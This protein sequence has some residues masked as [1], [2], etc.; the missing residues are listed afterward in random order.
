MISLLRDLK[1]DDKVA[2]QA[3]VFLQVLKDKVGLKVAIE[4]Q[5]LIKAVEASGK[6]TTRQDVGRVI[7]FYQPRL[8]EDGII[9]IEKIA[10]E[11]DAKPAKEAKG[12]P[13][14]PGAKPEAKAEGKG[15]KAA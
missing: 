5:D 10:E 14:K 6:M 11:K 12:E 15:K 1:E 13:S 8:Q 7:S 3:K 9:K 4:R 2:P